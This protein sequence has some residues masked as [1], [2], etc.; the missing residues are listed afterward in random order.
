MTPTMQSDLLKETTWGLSTWRVVEYSTTYW[1]YRHVS[2][3]EKL[4]CCVVDEKYGNGKGC[5]R[6]ARTPP[7]WCTPRGCG[8]HCTTAG[9]NSQRAPN[10]RNKWLGSKSLGSFVTSFSSAIGDNSQQIYGTWL[11][12]LLLSYESS[13]AASMAGVR[14]QKS[15]DIMT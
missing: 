11:V 12:L 5:D 2:V 10:R 7:A 9:T 4:D 8:L 15:E 13:S 3:Y 6:H 1:A 14:G